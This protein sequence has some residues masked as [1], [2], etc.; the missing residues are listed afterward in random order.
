MELERAG[1][2]ERTGI[3]ITV[4]ARYKDEIIELLKRMDFHNY[5]WLMGEE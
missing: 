5:M 3:I 4:G 2:T 1:L